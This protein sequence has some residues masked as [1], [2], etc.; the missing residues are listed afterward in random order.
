MQYGAMDT[1]ASSELKP[2]A[3]MIGCSK[4]R[5]DPTGCADCEQ[6]K[7]ILRQY[8]QKCFNIAMDPLSYLEKVHPA[9]RRKFPFVTAIR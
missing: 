4:C 1:P 8:R 2:I 5:H 9:D 3:E 6:S 7:A